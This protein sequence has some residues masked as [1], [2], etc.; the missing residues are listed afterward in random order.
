MTGRLIKVREILDDYWGGGFSFKQ[1]FMFTPNL[2][3]MIQFDERIVQ[4][5]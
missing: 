4:M 2:G 1:F 3:E 5:G